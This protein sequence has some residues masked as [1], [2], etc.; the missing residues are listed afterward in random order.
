MWCPNCCLCSLLALHVR[1]FAQFTAHHCFA[2]WPQN[3]AFL[4]A[5]AEHQNGKGEN[6]QANVAGPAILWIII[7][8]F[9]FGYWLENQINSKLWYFWIFLNKSQTSV[10]AQI[11]RCKTIGKALDQ[12]GRPDEQVVLVLK[13]LASTIVD[14]TFQI[15][16]KFK[17]S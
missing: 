12:I 16:G 1:T 7:I 10:P 8:I 17:K 3:A 15:Q 9:C 4:V 11:Q 6:E 2:H 5:V 13:E 14:N